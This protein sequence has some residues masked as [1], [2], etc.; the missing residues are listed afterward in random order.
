[1]IMTNILLFAIFLVLFSTAG[2]ILDIN[3]KLAVLFKIIEKIGE[4]TDG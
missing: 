1:M 4:E 3:K 2:M